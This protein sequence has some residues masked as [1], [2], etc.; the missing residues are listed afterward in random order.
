[1]PSR[2]AE[3]DKLVQM[4]QAF[5]AAV[6]TGTALNC[7]ADNVVNMNAMQVRYAERFVYSRVDDFDLVRQMLSDDPRYRTGPRIQVESD[8][9]PAN[10]ETR[11]RGS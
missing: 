10:S 7:S 8:R 1:M 2:I 4:P 11:G 6:A 9:C 3:I 5:L